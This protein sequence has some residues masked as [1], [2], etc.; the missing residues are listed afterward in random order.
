MELQTQKAMLR[1]N[2]LAK[3]DALPVDLRIEKSLDAAQQGAENIVFDA[4]TIVSGF[5]P[6]RSEIDPCLLYTSDAADD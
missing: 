1:A 5:F 4:G 3:R 6:I 2:A